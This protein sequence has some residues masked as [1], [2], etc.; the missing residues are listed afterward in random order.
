MMVILTWAMWS[1]KTWSAVPCEYSCLL[2]HRRNDPRGQSLDPPHQQ[3]IMSRTEISLLPLC[4]WLIHMHTRSCTNTDIQC[5][6]CQMLA[7][8][9][10]LKTGGT[11]VLHSPT[12][13]SAFGYLCWGKTGREE[14][15]DRLPFSSCFHTIK[16]LNSFKEN[17]SALASR[18]KQPRCCLPPF[19]CLWL[20]DNFPPYNSQSNQTKLSFSF[21]PNPSV[22]AMCLFLPEK[23][24]SNP[25]VSS[26]Y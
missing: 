16:T 4:L 6:Q 23:T 8:S 25:C 12:A 13:S 19:L 11:S 14:W 18:S 26:I 21:C 22:E 17:A 2:S 10:C 7:S 9:R 15:D 1:P 24:S 3:K 20:E 5:P